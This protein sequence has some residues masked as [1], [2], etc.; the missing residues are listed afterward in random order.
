MNKTT[1]I[2]LILFGL[3]SCSKRAEKKNVIAMVGDESLSLDELMDEI[4]PQVRG[5]ISKVE[6]REFVMN[7]INRQVLYQE[8]LQRKLD[9]REDVERAF[10]R[11]K[12]ELLVSRLTDETLDTEVGVTDEEIAEYYE[13]N[14]DAFTLEHSVVHAHHILLP[15]DQLTLAREVQRRLRNGEDAEI[16][17]NEVT[18]DSMNAWDWD[19]GYF[20]ENEVDNLIPDL[21]NQIFRLKPGQ[22]TPPIKSEYGYHV[23]KIIDKQEKGE[24][25]PLDQVKDEIRLK[26][27]TKKKNDRY[28]R[29][30]L[31]VKSKFSIR[32]NFELL[33]MSPFTDSLVASGGTR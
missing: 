9:E 17:Y 28:Q 1:A 27:E 4:P 13:S 22:V 16:I 7:W 14:K 12:K 10:D 31:Q 18:L 23:L 2:M 19:W 26:L 21:A 11:L 29:F 25:Q 15:E 20:S 33:R 3:I 24:L 8:A 6:I 32:T 5:N 30:L